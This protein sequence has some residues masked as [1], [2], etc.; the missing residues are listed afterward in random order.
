MIFKRSLIRELT[1]TAAALFTVSL[2]ILFTN[3]ILRLLSRAVGGRL[4]TD[5]I[6]TMLGFYALQYLH[7]LVAITLFL[8]V[9]LTLSRI[10]RDSEMIVWSSSGLPIYAWVRPIFKFAA[11]F[12]IVVPIMSL[13]LTPWA[14]QQR[15]HYE[16]QLESRDEITMLAP[17]LF[18]EFKRAGVV[19]FIES[20][21]PVTGT[22]KNVF[23]QSIDQKRSETV[24]AVSAFI[25]KK[26]NGDRF[27][28]MEN[29]SR[30]VGSPDTLDYQIVEFEQLGRRIEPAEAETI[31]TNI[32]ALPTL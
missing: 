8:T 27:L 15:Q 26:E 1:I 7:I 12:L 13:F 29:G 31:K 2:A 20:I 30:Y 21:N 14:Q 25:D 11:P 3:L 9:L 6:L 16:Q 28:V 18:R 23:L 24:S 4:V 22:I 5:G 10:Y 32:R 19:V 17:G